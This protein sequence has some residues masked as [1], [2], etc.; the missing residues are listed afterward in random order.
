MQ[1]EAV[2]YSDLYKIGYLQPEGWPDIIPSFK[3]YIDSN[4]CIPIKAVKNNK[5]VGLGACTIL[6]GT[7]WLAHIIVTPENRNQGIGNRIVDKLLKCLQLK[8][9]NTVL[10]IATELGFPV[11]LKAGFRKVTEYIF[12]KREEPFVLFSKLKNIIAFENK[13]HHVIK[14][15]DRKITGEDRSRLFQDYLENSWLFVQ[16]LKVEGF[17][18]PNL[19]EGLIVANTV[20]AGLEL[21]KL[22]H[23]EIDKAVLPSENKAGIA[24]LK[25]NGF[26]SK[27]MQGTRMILGEDLKWFPENI[28]SRISG[29]FG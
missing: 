7:S 19:C 27:P 3:F 6:G 15:L 24:F 17:F 16:N 8:G 9:V 1:I 4:F 5:I 2:E 22:K 26:V 23:V 14:E 13:Y 10:L 18:V 12:F 28:Y 11:Y 20:E 25:Q 29:N 21:M